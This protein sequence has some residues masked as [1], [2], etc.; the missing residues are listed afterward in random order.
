[1][2]L[3]AEV[4]DLRYH[5]AC[6]LDCITSLPPN[7]LCV[8]YR[9]E[10]AT[11]QPVRGSL[12]KRCPCQ[13]PFG[14]PVVGIVV[15]I[16]SLRLLLE[17]HYPHVRRWLSIWQ[18]R[19]T[20]LPLDAE[21]ATERWECEAATGRAAVAPD[22]TEDFITVHLTAIS[23]TNRLRDL[24]QKVEDDPVH[25]QTLYQLKRRYRNSPTSLGTRAERCRTSNTWLDA[26]EVYI[27]S[28]T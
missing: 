9:L 4:S 26:F 22:V 28:Q 2:R 14:R 20:L 3:Q 15:I 27:N 19:H 18:R 16:A 17:Y 10:R 5:L 23:A 7:S 8:A 11:Q 25:D 12:G 6:G 1:M 21:V 24:D 13:P